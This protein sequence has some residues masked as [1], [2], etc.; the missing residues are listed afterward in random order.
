MTTAA[1]IRKARHAAGFTQEELARQVGRGVRNVPDWESGK[2]V[3]RAKTLRRISEVTGASLDELA[4]DDDAA[5]ATSR[6]ADL[7]A[8]VFQAALRSANSE[9]RNDRRRSQAPISVDRRDGDRRALSV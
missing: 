2:R 6:A 9:S 5:A 7:L 8:A 3:P 4:Q 1:W